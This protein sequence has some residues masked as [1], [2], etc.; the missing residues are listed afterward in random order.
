MS[1]SLGNF[2][3]IRDI[4]QRYDAET[5]RFFIA[6]AHYRSPL[7]YSD[8]HLDDAR[9]ALRRLYQALASVA[10]SEVAID[11]TDPYAARFK[12]AMDDDFGTPEAVAVL[13]D[14]AGAVNRSRASDLA[15]LLKALGGCVGLLQ[16]EPESFLQ[17]GGAAA[18]LDPAAI[19]AQISA[20]AAAKAARDYQ[21]DLGFKIFT[22]GELRRLSFMSDFNDSVEGIAEA[23]NLL[24]SWQAGVG[25]S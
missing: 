25:G 20:R 4:L 16:S 10:P 14:L 13:F 11:W 23:D 21:Q 7:P 15:G 9:A 5:V 24:S 1:K 18:Q 6:R 17:A 22:D 12:A 19:E 3:T 2:F 8:A